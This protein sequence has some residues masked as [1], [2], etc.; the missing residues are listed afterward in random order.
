MTTDTTAAILV[1][2]DEPMIRRFVCRALKAE[3]FRT[4]EADPSL[5]RH[6]VTETGIGYRFVP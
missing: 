1:I 2:E 5:P 3:G 6:L 4:I